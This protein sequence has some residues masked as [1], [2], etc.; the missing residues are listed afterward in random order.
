MRNVILNLPDT[1]KANTKHSSVLENEKRNKET[2]EHKDQR[3]NW[4]L[5][6][7]VMHAETGENIKK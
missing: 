5:L 2:N 6:A 7:W 1:D 3:K 4:K